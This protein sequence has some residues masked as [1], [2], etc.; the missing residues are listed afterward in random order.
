MAKLGKKSVVSN[1]IKIGMWTALSRVFGFIR[2]RLMTEYLGVGTSADAFIT[3]YKIP[4]S[5]RKIFAEGAMTSI[6]VPTFVKLAKEGTIQEASALMTRAFLFFESLILIMCCGI[7]VSASSIIHVIAPGWDAAQIAL[8]V[9]LLQILIFFIFFVSSSALLA[10]AIQSKH[11]FLVPAAAPVVLNIV[12]IASLIVCKLYALPVSFF[13]YTIVLGGL[14][15]LLMHIYMYFKLHFTVKFTGTQRVFDEFKHVSKRFLPAFFSMS[16]LEISLF[17]DTSFASYLPAG[18]IALI[19]YSAR[20]MQIPLGVFGVAL[21]TILLPYFSR[22]STYAPRR[23]G[24]YLLE[25][26][27]LVVWFAIPSTLLICVFSHKLLATLLFGK[28]ITAAQLLQAQHILIAFTLGLFFFSF[29]KILLSIYYAYHNTT[30]PMIISFGATMLNIMLNWFLMQW[31][32]APGIALATT[33]SGIL[34]TILYVYFLKRCFDLQLYGRS[35]RKFCLGFGISLSLFSLLGYISYT[36]IYAVF[37]RIPAPYNY[38]FTEQFGVWFWA[39]PLV[40][41][42]AV[43]M[44][45]TRSWFN[46]STYFID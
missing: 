18:S 39:A 35:F 28:N 3:A 20:F 7:Y 5:L 32:K 41:M 38:F 13:S 31:L 14:F 22:I 4:N 24:F 37:I 42:A 30:V 1:T 40:M 25:A 21:S 34:Q 11:H 6:F 26:T 9:P 45:V 44:F 10:A 16:I 43:L 17:I 19:D 46:I 12:I 29:N 2:T 15:Q 8:T 27:K 33:I 36:S 23:L